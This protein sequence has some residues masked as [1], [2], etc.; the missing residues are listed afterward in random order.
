MI[1]SSVPNV[2]FLVVLFLMSGM[3]VCLVRCLVMWGMFMLLGLLRKMKCVVCEVLWCSFSSLLIIV[4]K[5][6]FFCAV[7]KCCVV[8]MGVGFVNGW[9]LVGL[10]LWVLFLVVGVIWLMVWVLCDLWFM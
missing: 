3:G 8:F 6:S 2:W 1:V 7:S 4:L 10:M 9:L 5:G